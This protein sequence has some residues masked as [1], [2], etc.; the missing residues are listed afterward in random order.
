MAVNANF[1][2]KHIIHDI[3]AKCVLSYNFLFINSTK[4]SSFGNHISI[5]FIISV[6]NI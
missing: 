3:V 5:F 6:N 4:T 2:V 1:L